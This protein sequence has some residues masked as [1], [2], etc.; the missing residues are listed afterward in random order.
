M[1]RVLH[2]KPDAVAVAD[3]AERAAGSGIRRHV[4]HDGAEGG[5][6][7]ARIGDAHHVLD[8]LA[9]ELFRDRQ[10]AGLRHR[11]RRMRAGILQHQNVVRPRRRAWDRRCARRDPRARKTPPPCPRCSN[12]LASAAERLRIAPLRREIA[13]QRDQP[14]LR[15]QRLVALGDDACGRPRRPA[16]CVEPLAQRLAGHRHGSRDAAGP[17]IR[18]SARPCRRPAKKSSM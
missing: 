7:H 9:R 1:R 18:A 17:A 8:A 15:L 10:I 5:A 6:A 14:A 2:R 13:E 3:Q 4:Q 11:R 12:S 16:P